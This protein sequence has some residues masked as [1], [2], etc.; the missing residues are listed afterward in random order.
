M[1]QRKKS[2]RKTETNLTEF[3]INYLTQQQ[4]DE[5]VQNNK[6]NENELY[7]TPSEDAGGGTWDSITGKPSTFPPS[8]HT[9]TKYD[10]GLGSVDNTSDS[11]K[12]VAY[13][14]T[15]GSINGTLD[16]TKGGTGSTSAVGA[17]TNLGATNIKFS[18]YEPNS[19]EQNEGD[20]WFL[21]SY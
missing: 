19:H 17:R 7:M 15:A 20:I 1:V 2:P 3:K 13:A 6:I 11:E 4:Y 14:T 9:H 16:I 10:V 12:R 18:Y 5:A 8:S 21:M